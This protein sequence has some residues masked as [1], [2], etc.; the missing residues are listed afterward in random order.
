MV[1]LLDTGI[2]DGELASI[3]REVLSPGRFRVSGKTDD[4]MA[5]TQ[6]DTLDLVRRQGDE[7]GYGRVMEA[8]EDISALDA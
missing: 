8:I 4:R 1:V 7:E 3:A 2:R 6:T 5:P